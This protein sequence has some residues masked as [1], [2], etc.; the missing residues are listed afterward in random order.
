MAFETQETAT[1]G[2]IQALLLLNLR[3]RE[4][5]AEQRDWVATADTLSSGLGSASGCL[6]SAAETLKKEIDEIGASSTS[7]E[8][9]ARQ[10]ARR[11]Q[12]LVAARRML[13]TA[14]FN[15]AVAYFN[16][17]SDLEARLYAERLRTMNNSAH[18]P[19]RCSTGSVHVPSH[20]P[21][22]HCVV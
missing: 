9:K 13:A 5:G 7:A 12:Q 21:L 19:G 6:E 3:Q 17:S 10:I 1:I 11:E 16:L 4:L 14:S 2:A 15:S 22:V 20:P 8:R 18:A